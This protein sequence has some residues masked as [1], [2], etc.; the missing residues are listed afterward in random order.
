MFPSNQNNINQLVGFDF[1]AENLQEFNYNYDHTDASFAAAA[2]AASSSSDH[3]Y[4]TS[5]V[6]NNTTVVL[7]FMNP[8]G[9]AGAGGA[10][11]YWPSQP[12]MMEPPEMNNNNNNNDDGGE[13]QKK[14]VT[15]KEVE[16]QRRQ[17]MAKLHSSLRDLLPLE[18]IKGKRSVADHMSEA[19]NY[20]SHL[21][22]RI[23]ELDNKKEKL[24]GAGSSSSRGFVSVSPCS[25]GVQ[26]LIS[27]DQDV[28]LSKVIQVLVEE[29]H[30][31]VSCVSNL[32]ND[33]LL[34]TIKS[35]VNDPS[36][37]DMSMLQQ[38]LSYVIN[39]N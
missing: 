37:I 9:A 28:L 4:Q 22:N 30:D 1:S 3:Q 11:A 39:C 35:E 29:G 18:F 10:S 2:A 26:I 6:N 5:F 7:D 25:I 20:I 14:L 34:H 33:K 38:K 12:E 19:V 23:R 36:G 24:K 32:V 31:I 21:Q 8:T 13:K 17:E 27:C 16:R 15:H